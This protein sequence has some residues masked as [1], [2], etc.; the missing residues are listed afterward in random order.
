MYIIP[1]VTVSRIIMNL[2]HT[3]NCYNTQNSNY[4]TSWSLAIVSDILNNNFGR[5]TDPVL[6]FDVVQF[7]LWFSRSP[8]NKH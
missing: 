7:P 3:Y 1:S 2:A 5:V 8:V 4:Y 6:C